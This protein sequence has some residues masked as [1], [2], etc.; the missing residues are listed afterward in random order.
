M[1]LYPTKTFFWSYHSQGLCGCSWLLLPP[2]A[3]GEFLGSRLL[4]G[5]MLVSES[6]V[7]TM[8]CWSE[9]PA[10]PNRVTVS[11]GLSCCWGQCLGLWSYCKWV[12]CW[13]LWPML[14]LGSRV[15][16]ML[17]TKGYA[18]LACPSLALGDLALPLAV[19]CSG[20]AGLWEN[21]S[22]PSASLALR[23]KQKSCSQ[24]QISS[25]WVGQVFLSCY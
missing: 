9:W 6:H 12:L 25:I 13:C 24:V 15:P 1:R 23:N 2:K 18:E 21:G 17:E 7:A 22:H 20:R 16:C 4:P 3:M 11:S 8:P 19:C 5:T 14:S 10:L